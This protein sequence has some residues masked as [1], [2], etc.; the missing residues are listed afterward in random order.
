MDVAQVAAIMKGFE[1]Y[2]KCGHPGDQLGN[3]GLCLGKLWFR[4]AGGDDSIMRGRTMLMWTPPIGQQEG[5]CTIKRVSHGAVGATCFGRNLCWQ[6]RLQ[7]SQCS[8]QV[9]NLS[10]HVGSTTSQLPV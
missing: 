3:K 8:C 9:G 7:V 2:E 1:S 5:G 10:L 4:V 6:C